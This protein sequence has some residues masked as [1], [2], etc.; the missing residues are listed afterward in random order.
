MEIPSILKTYS[1]I[2][3]NAHHNGAIFERI[4]CDNW[5][6]YLEKYVGDQQNVENA[7]FDHETICVS[8]N[9]MLLRKYIPT[10]KQII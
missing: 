2:D 8:L 5:R 7:A 1:N 9:S 10:I 6:K 3:R 4:I